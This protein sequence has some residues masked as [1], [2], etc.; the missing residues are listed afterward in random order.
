[1]KVTAPDLV[2]R[3]SPFKNKARDDYLRENALIDPAVLAD[4]L[5]LTEH[6]V[7][8]QLRRLGLR[9]CKHSPRKADKCATF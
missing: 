7:K 5:G 4:N 2:E 8:Q 1:M 9:K 6:F 3:R